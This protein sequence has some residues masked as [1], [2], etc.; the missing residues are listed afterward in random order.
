MLGG[1]DGPVGGCAFEGASVERTFV[2]A[3]YACKDGPRRVELRHPDD[4]RPDAP[5][6]ASFAVVVPQGE[7]V[8]P[9]WVNALATRVRS[10]EDAF[11]WTAEELAA[12]EAPSTP[13]A[14]VARHD[15][16]AAGGR[17]RTGSF[18]R[19]A[20]SIAGC[21]IF[22]ALAVRFATRST[23]WPRGAPALPS[24]ATFPALAFGLMA[25]VLLALRVPATPVHPDTTRDF[26]LA[27]DCL[28][29]APC[30]RGAHTSM[31]FLVQGALWIRTLAFARWLGLD[32]SGVQTFV[33]AALAAS[34]SVGL[35]VT[36][37]WFSMTTSLLTAAAWVAFGAIVAGLPRLWNPSL[38]PL[39]FAL[40][41]LSLLLLVERGALVYAVAAAGT[42]ALAV[43]CHV[44]FAVLAP[45]LV[46]AV[47]ASARRPA[48][49]MA[50]A[51]ATFGGLLFVDSRLTWSMNLHALTAAGLT[52]PV[53][54][55]LFVA[56]TAGWLARR[57]ML[58]AP[59]A[60]REAI[61]LGSMTVL[62]A[63]AALTLG[64][65]S[66]AGWYARYLAP[67]LPGAALGVALV[68]ACLAHGV[69]KAVHVGPSRVHSLLAVAALVGGWSLFTARVAPA[70]WTMRD[71]ETVARVVY[72]RV[73]TYPAVRAR[74]AT[75]STALLS[76][77]ALFEPAAGSRPV[78]SP[79]DGD[80]ELL[81]LRAPKARPVPDGPWAATVDLDG[82]GF[83]LV[84]TVHPFVDRGRVRACYA[85]L[86]A[87]RGDG[88]C[89]ETGYAREGLE[90]RA[91]PELAGL[92]DAFPPR[93]LEGFGALHETFA[94]RLVQAPGAAPTIALLTDA[95]D[96]WLI[97]D[98][99]GIGFHGSLPATR[100]GLEGGAGEGTLVLGRRTAAGQDLSDAYWP[101]AIIEVPAA[102]G[103]LLAAM[104]A[105]W[106]R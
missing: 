102:D 101:P 11:R 13:F 2:V 86:D 7:D 27:A 72:G 51:V 56:A 103:A 59:P 46:A 77:M 5:R 69:A 4:A 64:A 67:G 24:R 35:A 60:A 3:R 15:G 94:L 26:L 91:Y 29:G 16:S 57:R 50:A 81:L 32:P 45:V 82:Q 90:E 79:A 52:A 28:A 47:A 62:G 87:S 61:F 33:L 38:A 41:T 88:G 12:P 34:G 17:S 99:R 42:L 95:G 84:G 76:A 65:F 92:R 31:G 30:G 55:L 49:S 23:R 25:F 73:A 19:V 105:G 20:S 85:P 53:A 63:G 98:V 48:G 71:A 1:S 93:L 104:E 68:V 10:H 6:T 8:P 89:V 43:D 75:R 83:A 44:V 80:D 54:G 96:P 36:R 9:A 39:P 22:F 21:L 70:G 37:R 97:E 106:I 66:E 100:V 14:S 18:A 58:G 74:V 40:F 78:P